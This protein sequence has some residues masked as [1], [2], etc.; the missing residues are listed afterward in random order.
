[1]DKELLEALS[2]LL[3]EKLDKKLGV[4]ENSFDKKLDET[5]EIVKALEH[6]YV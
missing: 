3:D 2:N 4:L 6:K 5:Y 1:M